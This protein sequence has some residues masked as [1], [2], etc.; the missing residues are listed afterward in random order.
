MSSLTVSCEFAGSGH[1][2]KTFAF[3]FINETCK[4]L[5]IR[6]NEYDASALL[7]NM[8][9]WW[10]H[11]GRELTV[12][13]GLYGRQ[14]TRAHEESQ[15]AWV[16]LKQQQ[17]KKQQQN[18][19]PSEPT[20][21]AGADDTHHDVV[22]AVA[23]YDDTH[24][25]LKYL[26]VYQAYILASRVE[27]IMNGAA[28]QNLQCEYYRCKYNFD[29]SNITMEMPEKTIRFDYKSLLHNSRVMFRLVE[30]NPDVVWD[31][32]PDAITQDIDF[33][34]AA[35]KLSHLASKD[36]LQSEEFACLAFQKHR[37]ST[38][39]CLYALL[40][41]KVQACRKVAVLALQSEGLR[42]LCFLPSSRVSRT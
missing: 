2:I 4:D 42:V 16:A 8:R 23:A 1:Y 41:T 11:G 9:L 27:A 31:Y 32:L 33:M 22:I 29:V 35:K 30:D 12:P 17:K 24:M 34:A 40:S 18:S 15:S 6:I 7:C 3:D 19:K 26:P 38:L 36:L 14:R 37:H 5:E 13:A 20:A 39:P 28:Y 10:N 25:L 21:P